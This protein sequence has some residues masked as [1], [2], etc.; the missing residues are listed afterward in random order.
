M[1]AEQREELTCTI[2]RGTGR[3][4]IPGAH[5]TWCDGT[6][7]F[8]RGLAH[9]A[10]PP[11]NAAAQSV[12]QNAIT[13]DAP[14]GYALVPLDVFS[15]L[16]EALRHSEP[17]AK[18]Y[19]EPAARH[20][21][22]LA[23]VESLA[24]A[25]NEPVAPLPSAARCWIAECDRIHCAGGSPSFCG[26][27]PAL[28]WTDINKPPQ[29]AERASPQAVPAE[30]TS[31]RYIRQE[32]AKDMRAFYE[33]FDAAPQAVDAPVALREALA[34]LDAGYVIPPASRIH[35]ALRAALSQERPN[36]GGTDV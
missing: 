31:Q 25:P 36:E 9:T 8:L 33:A 2:C 27:D 7:K 34:E 6:G 24:A 3:E 18:H 12:V 32:V 19:P 21:A 15:L 23:T 4:G 26:A 5:C 13:G 11:I 16:A 1:S 30:T 10:E 20:E 14:S 35:K 22:A 17:K 29:G 28:A